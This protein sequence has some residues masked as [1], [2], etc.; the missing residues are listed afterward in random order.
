MLTWYWS[1]F[2]SVTL[3][4][5]VIL[6]VYH[7]SNQKPTKTNINAKSCGLTL[8]DRRTG[9]LNSYNWVRATHSDNTD[10]YEWPFVS[11]PL[12]KHLFVMLF[13]PDERANKNNPCQVKNFSSQR[14]SGCDCFHLPTDDSQITTGCGCVWH[15]G[16][17]SPR[18]QVRSEL[19]APRQQQLDAPP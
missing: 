2:I 8:A 7:E 9:P 19:L 3:W 11:F 4:Q 6:I 13:F 1:I 15:V 10:Q 17:V 18:P 14:T 5:Y 16:C 12:F